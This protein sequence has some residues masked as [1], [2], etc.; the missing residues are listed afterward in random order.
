MTDP[1][2]PN[3]PAGLLPGA[4]D[5]LKLFTEALAAMKK[6]KRPASGAQGERAPMQQGIGTFQM[7]GELVE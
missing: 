7:A 3:C 5:P 4:E 6:P 2:W 1:V